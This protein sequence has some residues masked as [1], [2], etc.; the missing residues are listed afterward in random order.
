MADLTTV[1]MAVEREISRIDDL[2]LVSRIREL[3]VEPYA[4][5][6][7]WDYGE[8]NEAYSCWTVLE[9]RDSNTGI[10]YCDRGFGPTDPWGLVFLSGDNMGIGMEANWYASLE[11]AMRESAAWDGPNPPGYEGRI[12]SKRWTIFTRSCY[13][14]K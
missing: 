5:L 1:R 8:H 13:P 14:S 2:R 11:G 7:A 6:R 3:L 4:V 12:K 10:A 9:H